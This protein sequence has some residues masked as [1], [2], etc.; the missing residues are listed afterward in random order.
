MPR[1]ETQERPRATAR[2]AARGDRLSAPRPPLRTPA[3][4][5]RLAE[6]RPG[7]RRLMLRRQRRLLRPLAFLLLAVPL[8]GM[9]VFLARS[10]QPGTSIA[11][12]RERLGGAMHFTVADVVIEGREK[13]PEGL[14]R[15]AL[16]VG[17]GDKLLGFS[18][19]AA[20]ARIEQLAWVSS[21]TVERRLPAT[22]VVTLVERRP[23]AVWQSNGKFVLIDRQGQVV[24]EQDPVKDATAFATLPLVVGAGAPEAAARLL[25]LLQARPELKSRVAAAVRVGERRWNL[26]LASGADV[27]LPED[28]A[29]EAMDRLI[30]LQ[31]S[32]QLLDRPVAAIDLRLGDRLVVRPQQAGGSEARPATV[33][34]PT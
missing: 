32:Q 10:V 33:K 1:L 16:G 29:P 22:V 20:R 26:R 17:R 30:E 12:W 6:S 11:T 15:A 23:F 19:E 25:D 13:T 27:L 31:A 7:W 4:P 24:A 18:L 3:K 2:T 8:V 21:A 34:R 5:P 28:H 9:A 14:L